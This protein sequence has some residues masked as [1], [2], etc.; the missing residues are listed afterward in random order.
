MKVVYLIGVINGTLI[1]KMHEMGNFKIKEEVV[2][3][4]RWPNGLT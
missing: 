2:Y 3:T 4:E 1:R